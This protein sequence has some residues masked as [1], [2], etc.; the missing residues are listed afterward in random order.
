[1]TSA[2]RHIATNAVSAH[3]QRVGGRSIAGVS[4]LPSVTGIDEGRVIVI[5]LSIIVT[6]IVLISLIIG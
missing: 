3:L 2:S 4:V 5:E 6:I 1:M